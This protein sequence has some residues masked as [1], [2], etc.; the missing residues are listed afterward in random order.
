MS[1]L[2]RQS[3]SIQ[4]HIAV[5]L[6]VSTDEQAISGLGMDAQR[7]RCEA[8]IVVDGH[9]EPIRYYIDEG[10]SGMKAPH[11]RKYCSEMLRDMQEG[12]VKAVYVASLDRI[13]RKVM[14][15]LQVVEEMKVCNVVFVSCKEKLDTSTYQGMF[16]LQI[17]AALSEMERNMISQRTLDALTE[18]GKRDGEKGGR[19]PYGYRRIFVT[20]TVSGKVHAVDVSIDSQEAMIVVSIFDMRD[21]GYPMHRIASEL[22]KQG[23]VS[24]RGTQWYASGVREILM[25]ERSYRG[26]YRGD[27]HVS[28]P[29]ILTVNQRHAAR[30]CQEQTVQA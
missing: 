28:W 23:C 21:M 7:T 26:G 6:R 8:M 2:K 16:V 19:L 10:I 13:A 25:N 9:T 11:T 30:C 12:K 20:D 14:Y 4:Q 1:K 24:P 27:S 5:Y 22:N 29:T 3:E 17:F 18:K 15:T